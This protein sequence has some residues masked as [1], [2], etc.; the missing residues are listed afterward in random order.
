[1]ILQNEWLFETEDEQNLSQAE[2]K[3]KKGGEIA[4][5]F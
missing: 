4:T 3:T 1:M 5:S 2:E